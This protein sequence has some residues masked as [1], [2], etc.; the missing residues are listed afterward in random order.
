M[1]KI[2]LAAVMTLAMV[3]M[4]VSFTSYSYAQGSSRPSTGPN[5]QSG[6]LSGTFWFDTYSYQPVQITVTFVGTL[7]QATGPIGDTSFTRTISQTVTPQ[8]GTPFPHGHVSFFAHCLRPGTWRVSAYSN[9]TGPVTCTTTVVGGELNWYF[10]LS[11]AG[12]NGPSCSPPR[13]VRV[14]PDEPRPKPN[15]R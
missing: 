10:N 1:K 3:G 13:Y 15:Y 7:V 4:L 12:G 11:V 6:S 8:G 2:F 5:D 14:R 9:L